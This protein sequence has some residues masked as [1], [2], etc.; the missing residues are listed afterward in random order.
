MVSISK[1]NIKMGAI[2]SVSL[3][4]ELTCRECECNKKCYAKRMER[5][6]PNVKAAYQNNLDILV[7]D[8]ATYWREVEAA[9]MAS[10]FFRFHVS[11]DIPDSEYLAH[12]VDIA[13]GNSHCE[14]LCFTK[15]YEIV[16]DFL[17]KEGIPSNLHL[18]FSVWTGLEVKNPYRLPEA[19][20]RYKDG[21]TTAAE[22]AIP[23]HGNCTDCAIVDGGCW[24]LK[25]NVRYSCCDF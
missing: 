14:I 16:N 11:G 19:H 3:P 24:S 23:C 7:N 5:L 2:Q 15:K 17:E 6:R 1:G 18:I 4:A 12:M 25:H 8:P 21:S 9:V 13:E 10:R 20:V 22:T